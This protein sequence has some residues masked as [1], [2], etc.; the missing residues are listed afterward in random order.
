MDNVPYAH[1]D[2]SFP[3]TGSSDSFSLKQMAKE[4]RALLGR[5]K[6]LSN[7]PLVLIDLDINPPA[8]LLVFL[9]EWL[10][11]Q[12]LSCPVAV[13]DPE[14]G[15]YLVIAEGNGLSLF[16]LLVLS[17]ESPEGSGFQTLN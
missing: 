3:Q 15:C 7:S 4:L 5:A 6:D 16:E 1:L 11:N 13:L 8:P 9:G 14:R 12:S 10:S 17:P 2:L